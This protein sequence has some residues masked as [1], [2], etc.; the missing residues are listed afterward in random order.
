MSDFLTYATVKDML[1]KF[2]D[3]AE[4]GYGEYLVECNGEYYL[5]KK[6]DEAEINHEDRIVGFGGYSG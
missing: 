5:A 3:L 6:A 2:K 4:K 1:Q